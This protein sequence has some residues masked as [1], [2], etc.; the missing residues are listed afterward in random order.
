M[1]VVRERRQSSTR[2]SRC[3]ARGRGAF[4]DGTLYCERYPRAAAARRGAAPRGRARDVVAVGERD[5]SVQRRH[6]KV[7]EEAP[8]PAPGRAAAC[9][10][11]STL[12]S[13]SGGGRIPRAPARSS[14]S[15][16]EERVL[17]PRAERAYPGRASGHGGRHRP[18]PRRAADSH[19][20][21][22]ATCNGAHT[23]EGHAVEVRLYAEDPRDIPSRRPDGSSALTLPEERIR[24]DAGVE[25]G[26]E[27]GIAYDPMIAKLI[28]HGRDARGSARTAR[29]GARR[30][31]G[32]RRHD[33]PSVP[34]LARLS[35]RRTRRERRRRLS[36][37][38]IRRSP[39]A[40]S[41]RPPAIWRAAVAAEP[42]RRPRRIA[43]R[44]RRRIA[45]RGRRAGESTVRAPMPGTV[46]RVEVEPGDQ[47]RARQ[48]LV[49][50]EAMKMEIPVHS[51]FD[52]DGERGARRRG[53]SRRRRSAAGRARELGCRR[54]LRPGLD[55]HQEHD[56]EERED[57][58]AC[59]RTSR[60]TRGAERR[61]RAFLSHAAHRAAPIARVEVRER[62][63]ATTSDAT[64]Q[65]EIDERL[66]PVPVPVLRERDAR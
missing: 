23:V 7:L 55:D 14:S 15:S 44:R 54:A 16:T 2:R 38:S 22:R 46:I 53:R 62:R 42:S 31:R 36:S 9:A 39:A 11:C 48:P 26:D 47:V 43:S 59:E 25:E 35:S 50:L 52:G 27:V 4:G 56:H 45:S 65:P 40:R 49:V 41:S 5:C 61:A 18:R 1:R 33:E 29:R 12:R 64:D 58:H 24:V 19:R 3:R 60:S 51:P 13:H 32:R 28:A 66:A 63:R 20:R 6:Q 21:G 30:D 8:A 17:L 10:A 34:P 57:E 37:P